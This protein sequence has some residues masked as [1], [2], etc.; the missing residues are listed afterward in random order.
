VRRAFTT[1]GNAAVL[2]NDLYSEK[3]ESENDH[4]LPTVLMAREGL[5]HRAA[6]LRTVE[7]HN[8]LM[9]TFV[10]LAASLSAAGSPSLRRFLADPWA[11]LGGSREWHATSGR[12]H[13]PN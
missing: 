7:I 5:S 8:E 1:A 2:I 12:Y 4:N 6:V 9:E 10:T 13:S 11:W 3:N